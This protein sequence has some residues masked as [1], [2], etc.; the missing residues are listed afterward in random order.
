LGAGGCHS[1]QPVRL[2]VM[3]YNMHHGHGMDGKFDLSRTIQVL[4][5][6]KPDLLALQEVDSKCERSRR[7]DEPQELAAQTGMQAAFGKTIDWQGG[8][9]G[10][11]ILSRYPILHQHSYPL[12]NIPPHEPRVLLEVGVS[13]AGCE[14][15]FYDMDLDDNPDNAERFGSVDLFKQTVEQQKG[16]VILGGDLFGTPDHPAI[17]KLLGF[18]TDA[19][20]GR[21]EENTCPAREPKKR[22]DYV[23]Y[24]SNPHLRCISCEVIPEPLAAQHRPVLAVFEVR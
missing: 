8:D 24:R 16:L 6:A 10:I 9:Y 7:V 4:N 20:A 11:A 3:T 23:M 22:I 2:R 21:N 19:C 15:T 1:S 13:V 18:M 14:L 12:L 5:A 17:R